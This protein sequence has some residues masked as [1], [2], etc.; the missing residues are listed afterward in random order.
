MKTKLILPVLMCIL[1]AAAC[2]GG[3]D[4]PRQMAAAAK[5]TIRLTLVPQ[6]ALKPGK[7]VTVLAKL[8][9]IRERT[10]ITEDQLEVVHTQ[11]IHLLLID[12]TLT[13]YQH[14][15]PQPTKTPGVYSFSFTP[16]LSG[17]YR[18]W[19][20]ITPLGGKQQFVMSE[21]L[22]AHRAGTINKTESHEA[23]IGS[24][25]FTLS[26]DK[27]PVEGSE[28][29]GKIHVTDKKGNAVAALEPIMGAFAHIVGFYDDFRT[30]AHTHPMGKEPESAH[31]RGG[32]ELTFHFAPSKSG[33]VKLFAQVKIGGKEIFVPFGVMVKGM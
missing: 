22:G 10:V 16:K 33:F 29:M 3:S 26:F 11:K 31:D 13:D 24:Y 6:D 23:V 4:H 27:P 8:N 17:G 5:P 21:D 1:L 7:P 30:V 25:R 15:H 12:P 19:A 20:D 9:N 2:S 14:I 28:S 32:P 18:A